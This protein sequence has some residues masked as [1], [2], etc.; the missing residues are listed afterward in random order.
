VNAALSLLRPILIAHARETSLAFS[1]VFEPFRTVEHRHGAV[2][3]TDGGKA[4]G[5]QRVGWHVVPTSV[6]VGNSLS[7]CVLPS[8]FGEGHHA[9]AQTF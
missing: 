9:G 4:F 8:P 1:P 3:V 2:D 6:R 7:V 5:V